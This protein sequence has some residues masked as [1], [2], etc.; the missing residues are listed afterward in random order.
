M[1]AWR[2]SASVLQDAR[3]NG[4]SSTASDLFA[5]SSATMVHGAMNPAESMTKTANVMTQHS[6][7]FVMTNPL[8]GY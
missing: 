3:Q 4:K 5:L 2:S 8:T 7:C 1:L 6:C